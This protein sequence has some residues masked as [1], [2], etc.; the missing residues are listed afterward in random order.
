MLEQEP[1]FEDES[2]ISLDDG[3]IV[4][5]S[6]TKVDY[7]LL[8]PDSY[9]NLKPEFTD[10]ERQVENIDFGLV[11]EDELGL[12]QRVERERQITRDFVPRDNMYSSHC[13]VADMMGLKL[14]KGLSAV[15][16]RF[17]HP[18]QEL[19][20]WYLFVAKDGIPVIS[21]MIYKF[22]GD[23]GRLDAI[24]VFEGVTR[25]IANYFI[26]LLSAFCRKENLF[27]ITQTDDSDMPAPFDAELFERN[28]FVRGYY[29]NM[30][31]L[32]PIPGKF[33]VPLYLI[34]EK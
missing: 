3:T 9:G 10:I 4:V 30:D 13:Y 28:G 31:Q 29:G 34:V 21:T 2:M 33:N 26:Q 20:T 11:S 8:F 24:D 27:L 22:L 7:Y 32:Q 15:V 25:R 5:Y 17:N 14:H 23:K 1:F 19:D 6:E 18:N 12:E 16:G